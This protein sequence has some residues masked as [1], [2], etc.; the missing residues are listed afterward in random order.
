MVIIASINLILFSLDD[1]KILTFVN[2]PLFI[3][4]DTLIHQSFNEEDDLR[5]CAFIDIIR[6][7]HFDNI[8]KL[9]LKTIGLLLK[10]ISLV[11]SSEVTSFTLEPLSV[12]I[13][14]LYGQGVTSTSS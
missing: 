8:I 9:I 13:K 12:P 6:P 1:F 5:F 3:F 11:V 10:N 4:D 2:D 14:S 7:S